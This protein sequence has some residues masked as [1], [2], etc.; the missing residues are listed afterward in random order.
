MQ[1]SPNPHALHVRSG[2]YPDYNKQAGYATKDYLY[3]QVAIILTV[4]FDYILVY[5]HKNEDKVSDD[6]ADSSQF[7][8]E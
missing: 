7:S 8:L 6:S 1:H 2:T 3:T 4:G 5:G